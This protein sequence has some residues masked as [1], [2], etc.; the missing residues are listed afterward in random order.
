M[1]IPVSLKP[2]NGSNLKVKV[3][4]IIYGMPNSEDFKAAERGEIVLG[5][6]LFNTFSPRW[7]VVVE[8]P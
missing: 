8:T 3:V 7:Q 6:C 5:G 4:P 1:Q 2:T